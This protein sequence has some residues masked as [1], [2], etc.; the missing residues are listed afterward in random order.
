MSAPAFGPPPLPATSEPISVALPAYNP[1]ERNSGNVHAFESDDGPSFSDL[2][3]II[4]PLQ[5][6]PIVNM[7]YQNL[8]GDRQGAVANVVGGTLWGGPLGLFCATTD[9]AVQDQTG[10]TMSENVASLFSDDTPSDTKLADSKTPD[11]SKTAATAKADEPPPP[12]AAP[13]PAVTASELS[14]DTAKSGRN[15]TVSPAMPDGLMRAGEFLVFGGGPIAA[16]TGTPGNLTKTADNRNTA[17]AAATTPVISNQKSV[18]SPYN[19]PT[20]T[21][22]NQVD[23]QAAAQSPSLS[24]QGDFLVFG[25]QGSAPTTSLPNTATGAANQNAPSALSGRGDEPRFRPVPARTNT[26][27]PPANLPPPT[28]GPAAVPFS[29]VGSQA[30]SSRDNTGSQDWFSSAFTQGMD[31][32]QKP[33]N[34]GDDAPVSLLN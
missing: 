30:K 5:H 24:R 29:Q 19:A 16:A 25:E 23:A 26:A 34:S 9:L 2:I 10:K 33:V 7:I 11:Q 8:T 17:T 31:K 32:Y 4:N 18:S 27:T 21:A 12:A 13:Q 1:A 22:Q 3:D 28:T 6:I 15:D 14:T 20:M